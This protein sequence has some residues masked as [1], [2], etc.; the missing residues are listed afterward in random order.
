MSVEPV[1]RVNDE[2]IADYRNLVNRAKQ[3]HYK[4]MESQDPTKISFQKTAFGRMK[5]EEMEM[6]ETNE[7]NKPY[8]DL[9][10]SDGELKYLSYNADAYK[11]NET[12]I[13]NKIEPGK[14][15]FKHWD[16]GVKDYTNIGNEELQ[17]DYDVILEN[18]RIEKYRGRI[19][20]LK[21]EKARQDEENG[22]LN[23]ITKG[24]KKFGET[25][26]NLLN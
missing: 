8:F 19:K 5:L 9:E 22:I 23:K 25:I 7:K 26:K 1:D 24:F 11:N 12:D 21:E 2:F 3:K 17:D 6:I 20:V 4:A 13:F 16:L 10:T 15:D 14:D 18:G